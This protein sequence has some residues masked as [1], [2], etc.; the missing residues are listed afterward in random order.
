MV[1]SPQIFM[2]ASILLVFY[3]IMLMRWSCVKRPFFYFIGTLGLL[4]V[5]VGQFFVIGGAARNRGLWIV[6]NLFSTIGSIVAF[7]GLVSACYGAKLP[8]V[9]APL[10]PQQ[11]VRPPAEQP[12]SAETTDEQ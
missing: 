10:Y 5:F 3:L 7:L 2:A 6:A 11:G 12:S 9:E 8:G 1:G 4:A